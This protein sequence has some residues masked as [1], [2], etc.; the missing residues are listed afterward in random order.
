MSV[1]CW[2][3]LGTEHGLQP[4]CPRRT[5][6]GF[7]GHPATSRSCHRDHQHWG[8]EFLKASSEQE[9]G[10]PLPPRRAPRL[11]PLH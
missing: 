5:E 3:A 9:D 6:Q 1:H 8:E 7:N 11:P 4:T 10:S 2:T